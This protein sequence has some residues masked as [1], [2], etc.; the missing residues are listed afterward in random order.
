MNLCV[1][2][3]VQYSEVTVVFCIL[4]RYSHSVM[5]NICLTVWFLYW[6]IIDTDSMQCVLLR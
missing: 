2:S 6:Y 5:L 3:I 1:Q 4:V